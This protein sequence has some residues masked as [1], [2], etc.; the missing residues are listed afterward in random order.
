[1]SVDG[2]SQS[3]WS[4]QINTPLGHDRL[5]L[6]A[7]EGEE[8]LSEPFLF[9]LTMASEYVDLDISQAVGE[10]AHATL[11]NGDGN[12]RYI[13]GIITRMN[14]AGRV[15][16]AEL[17]P[18]FWLLTLTTD[19]R[20]FQNLSIPDIITRVFSDY[21]FTDYRNSLTSS[22]S[23][24][25]YCVQYQ[26]TAFNF[27]SRLMEYAGISYFFEHSDSAHTLVLADDPSAY[28][29]CP[30]A[31]SVPYL[32]LPPERDWLEG[33]RIDRVSLARSVTVEQ[34]QTDDYN[35]ETPSTELKV[36][37][38]SG[39]K[40]VYEYPGL[41]QKKD[42]GEQVAKCRMEEF[43]ASKT[44]LNGDSPVRFLAPGYRFTLTQY[45]DN[46]VNGAYVLRTVRHQASRREYR[47][48][49]SAHP[50]DVRFRPQRR[51]PKP[52][53]AGSQTAFIVGKSGEEVW[54]DQ[55]GRVKVQ[56]HW[57]QLGKS[58][59]NSSRWVRV[60]Q[61]W[62]GKSWGSFILPRIGQ[63]VV[64]SFLEGD[65]DQPLVSG[66]VY[67]GD[68]PVPYALPEEETK[69]TLK[70]NSSKGGGG[71][72]EIRMEDKAGE[73]ELYF[74]AQKD[75]NVEVENDQTV[76]VKN[77]WSTT[78]SEG[79]ESLTVAKGNR[80]VTVDTGNEDHTVKGTRT[81][82]VTGA[83]THDNEDDF[84]QK[85]SGNFTLDV[86]GDITIKA[87]GSIQIQSGTDL[88]AEAGTSL[89]ATAGTSLSLQGG[90]TMEVKGSA[91]GT[92]DGGGVLTVKGGLVK[93]N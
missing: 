41:Y 32:P 8:Y 93:I 15:Y 38:G 76:T 6:T 1:M 60:A 34:F 25:E 18:W 67:N 46:T 48:S 91:S 51:A 54:T 10:A 42:A 33:T 56:F 9:N 65:P 17:R 79:N 28:K 55:Y 4:L 35:F 26:E 71:S 87:S 11:I 45:P 13:H 63:E 69:T 27:V 72:N 86:G 2:Y 47:N 50:A 59:E 85:I 83:E 90:T 77:D 3:N 14:H 44:V 22:Y 81:L 12:K 66:C 88:T 49:F 24:L 92:V 57:D 70:S 84:T 68:F 36:M 82:S 61:N 29:P 74:H 58:D 78:I 31:A 5:L 37:S 64:V 39:N 52:R 16:F 40:K 53:I 62:A 89:N 73:E 20:I 21:G 43:E 75:M 80:T 23:Q 19:S 30:N 7:L